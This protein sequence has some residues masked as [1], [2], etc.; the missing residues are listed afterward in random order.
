MRIPTL[1]SVCALLG[2]SLWAQDES[3]YYF[4]LGFGSVFS[5]SADQPA[6]FGGSV[7]FDPGFLTS[8]ALGRTFDF[9]E[10][11]TGSAEFEALYQYFTTDEDDM[12]GL[13]LNAPDDAK[14]FALMINGGLDW[15]L[16]EQFALYGLLGVGWA[17][18]IEYTS[19]DS[20]NLNTL[21][22]NGPAFQARFGCAYTFGGSYSFRVGYR[23]FK[24][25]PIDIEDTDVLSTDPSSEI[26][27]AQHS[28][29][30]GFRWGL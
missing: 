23:F 6:N 17:P 27:V 18:V 16:T 2:S 8:A 30:I 19:W 20:A 24:T 14:S 5:E 4:Q 11:W 29:E 1:L 9:G 21:D 22:D 15:N 26:D 7:G 28:I 13:P 3:P 12:A 10:R 25:E